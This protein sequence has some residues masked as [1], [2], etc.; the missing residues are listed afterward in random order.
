MPTMI[1]LP[2]YNIPLQFMPY[3]MSLFIAILL[4]A[5]VSGGAHGS[6]L[7]RVS[8]ILASAFFAMLY[9]DA[10]SLNRVEADLTRVVSNLPPGSRVVAALVDSSSWRLNGLEHAVAGACLGRCFDYGN[11]EPPSAEFRVR[12]SGPNGV[13]VSDTVAVGEITTG[14]H[15]VTPG[16]APLYIAC[17]PKQGEAPFELRKAGVGE[18]SCQVRL[19]A[20]ITF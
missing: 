14:E 5:V 17:A 16:E 9:L 6:S 3:R 7:T 15:T 1:L 10:R 13:V 19:P 2:Q 8:G 20:T 4:C 18:T 12:V 11:Y